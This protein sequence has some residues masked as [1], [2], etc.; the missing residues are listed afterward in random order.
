MKNI[1]LGLV[2]LLVV[3]CAS[4]PSVSLTYVPPGN[5]LPTVYVTYQPSVDLWYL[6]EDYILEFQ[7]YVFYDR[8]RHWRRS[9]L[10]VKRIN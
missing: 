9:Y 7:D 2:A 3:S 8:K 5:S 1:I 4:K 10:E 6:T